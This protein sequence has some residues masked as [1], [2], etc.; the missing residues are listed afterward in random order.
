MTKYAFFYNNISFAIAESEEEKNL[1]SP[2]IPDSILKTIT[3]SQFENVKNFKS[4]LKIVDDTVLEESL[5]FVPLNDSTKDIDHVK[6]EIFSHRDECINRVSSWL[7]AHPNPNAEAER[8]A[9]WEDYKSKLESVD[10]DSMTFPLNY[11]TF[12]EWFNSQPNYPTK[13]PLQLP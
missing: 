4:K 8:Y 1:L 11:E 6:N 2:A 9:Y 7:E 13:S 3:D 10:T 5:S 12:M